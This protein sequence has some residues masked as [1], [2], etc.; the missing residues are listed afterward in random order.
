MASSL[1]SDTDETSLG[2]APTQEV[3]DVITRDGTVPSEF[4]ALAREQIL[5]YTPV[6]MMNDTVTSIV[7]ENNSTYFITTDVIGKQYLSKNLI[8]APGMRDLLPT[9]PGLAAGRGKGIYCMYH[10]YK[11]SLRS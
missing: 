11:N 2:D 4:R 7:P 5:V 10:P 9:T 8:L 3:H 1:S 6:S